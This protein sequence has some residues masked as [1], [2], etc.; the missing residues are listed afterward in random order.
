MGGGQSLDGWAQMAGRVVSLFFA[1]VSPKTCIKANYR[2]AIEQIIV[3]STNQF[4]IRIHQ[5]ISLMR[6]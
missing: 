6:K 3:E 5:T 4:Q 2:T 1:G